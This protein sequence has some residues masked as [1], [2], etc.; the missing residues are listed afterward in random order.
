MARW[1]HVGSYRGGTHEVIDVAHACMVDIA[2]A[3]GHELGT[4][5]DLDI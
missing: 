1:I 2:W 3:T 5:H 4:G